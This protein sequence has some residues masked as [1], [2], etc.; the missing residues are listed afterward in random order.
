MKKEWEWEELLDAFTLSSVET[1]FL[2]GELHNQLGQAVLLKTFQ[3]LG[4][5]P[6]K[7]T[8]VPASAVEYIARQ[9]RC[10]PTLFSKYNWT[11]GRVKDHRQAIR[12]WLGFREITKADKTALKQWVIE[13]LLPNEHRSEQMREA[14]QRYL[15]TRGIEQTTARE[16][17][18]L[19]R[20][21]VREHETILA[22]WGLRGLTAYM[23][24]GDKNTIPRSA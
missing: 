16:L 9:L 11:K 15:R 22:L 3:Y 20:S 12:Q 21:A 10:E 1:E 17:H 5:F 24:S 23:G 14:A 18:Q 13:T 2:S 4:R 19:L 6:K 8:D 7:K